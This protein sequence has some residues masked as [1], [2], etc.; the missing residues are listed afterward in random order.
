MSQAVSHLWRHWTRFAG[1]CG[2][3][4]LSSPAFSGGPLKVAGVSY[5]NSSSKGTPLT[6][7]ASNVTYYTDLGDLSPVLKQTDA[8]AFVADAFSRWTGVASASL[9]VVN[10]G[11][12]AEDVNG[13]NVSSSGAGLTLPADILP[14]ATNKPVAIV[15]DYDGAV[16]EAL[17]GTGSSDPSFCLTNSTYGGP[18][19]YSTDGHFVHALVVINGRCAATSASLAD[20]KYHLTRTLGRVLGLDWSQLNGNVITGNPPPKAEDYSGFPLMHPQDPLCSSVTTCLRNTG[21]AN[22]DDRA[23]LSRLY[24]KTGSATGAIRGS[25]YFVDAHGNKTQPMQGVNIVARWMD[26]ASGLTSGQYAASCVSGFRFRGNAGNAVTG[27]TDATGNRFDQFGSDDTSLEGSFD[28]SGLE[29]PDGRKTATYQISVEAIDPNFTGSLGVGPYDYGQVQPAGTFT[30]VN[31]TVNSGATTNQ[32]IV[33]QGSAA[34]ATDLREPSSFASPAPVP[35]AGDWTASLNGYGDAD[36]YSFSGHANNSL[37]ILVTAIDGSTTISADGTTGLATTNKAMPLIGIWDAGSVAGSPPPAFVGQPFNSLQLGVTRLDA[38]ILG[39]SGFIVGIADLRGDGRPDFRYRARI[40][41]GD[42]VQPSRISAQG[43]SLLTIQGLGFRVGTTVAV[44]IANSGTLSVVA[45]QIQSIAPPGADG[46][47]DVTLTDPLTGAASVISGGLMMGAGPADSVILLQGSNPA[48][49]VGGVSQNPFR[50]RVV[51]SDGVTPVAGATVQ[52]SASPVNVQFAACGGAT[53]CSVL[54]GPNGEVS[55]VITPTATGTYTLKASL[56]PLTY[57]TPSFVQG[58][59][60]AISSSLIFRWST[61]CAGR[62][63]TVHSPCL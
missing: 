34:I 56:A 54:S 2:I 15:Y 46:V 23:A 10:G 36:Y 25:V 63:A 19:A 8:N 40:F 13:G 17:L 27:Y 45:N 39:D 44:G 59:L 26:P 37:S 62:R 42:T 49:P 33:M 6:W 28:L 4:L 38:L 30:A 48:T 31:V 22:M 41:Y 29:F 61:S 3:L 53:T 58:T 47:Q 32:D 35:A 60:S 5:F 1:W 7:S 20:L 16:T 11:S 18:D 14:T 50:V 9:T 55:S 24:P 12:L 52:L 57:T 43:G 21:V 51:Q